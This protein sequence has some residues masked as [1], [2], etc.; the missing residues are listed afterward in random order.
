MSQI[1]FVVDSKSEM[2]PGAQKNSLPP[3]TRTFVTA[4]KLQDVLLDKITFVMQIY[5]SVSVVRV[6]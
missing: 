1:I 2:R 4:I 6:N 5:M 3:V